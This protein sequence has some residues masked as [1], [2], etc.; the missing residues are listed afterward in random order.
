MSAWERAVRAAGVLA[1]LLGMVLTIG[2]SGGT[3][4]QEATGALRIVLVDDYGEALGGGCF[5]IVD[6][7]GAE[8]TACDDDGDGVAEVEGL[9][10]GDVTIAETSG[11]DGYGLAPEALAVVSAETVSSIELVS[12]AGVEPEEEPASGIPVENSPQTVQLA[13]VTEC[14]GV[15][16]ASIE[17]AG[18]ETFSP[19]DI[20]SECPDLAVTKGAIASTILVGNQAQ[21]W[22]NVVN[23]GTGT[24]F[25]VTL[26]DN[27]P[28][29]VDWTVDDEDCAIAD[30]LLTCNF[31]DLAPLSSRQ[32]LVS[33]GTAIANCGVLTNTA[34]ASA[35]NEPAE[36]LANNEA[37]AE[38]TATCPILFYLKSPDA[39]SVN[40]GEDIGFTLS[41][42]NQGLASA[43]SVTLVDH[44]PQ[45]AGLDWTIDAGGN[46][47]DCS[48]I[49]DEMSCAF[50]DLVAGGS[51]SVHISSSTTAE[52]C[53]VVSNSADVDASNTA[54][55]WVGADVTVNCPNIT[56]TKDAVNDEVTTGDELAFTLTIA[57][58]GQ[59]VATD[60]TV[61]DVLPEGI[62]WS[63]DEEGCE[64]ES[65]TLAC[66][67]PELG[68]VSSRLLLLQG[69]TSIGMC[70]TVTN[71]ASVVAANEPI[72]SNGDNSSTDSVE[73]TC[74]SVSI[75]KTGDDGDGNIV[76]LEGACFDLLRNEAVFDSGCTDENGQLEFV[77]IPV[78][79]YLLRETIAP[80][81]YEVSPISAPITLEPGE[82]AE[83]DI[84][85]ELESVEFPVFALA[86][87]EDPGSVDPVDIANGVLPQGCAA[88][89]GVSFSVVENGGTPQSFT[90][91][92]NGGFVVT[93][94]LFSTVEVTEDFDTVPGGYE[95][96]FDQALLTK[97]IESVQSD[98]AGLVFVSLALPTP[99]PTSTSTP[100]PTLTVTPAS[101]GT[102]TPPATIES[103][104]TPATGAPAPSPTP[105][106]V[107][108][109]PNT[110]TGPGNFGGSGWLLGAGLLAVL[111]LG[112][113]ALRRRS[114]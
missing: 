8:Q 108:S 42:E 9:I 50:G 97:T 54:S 31:G 63:V 93:V 10:E 33:G 29:G 99:E 51:L 56:I 85:N 69:E 87:L 67:F 65:G 92:V 114:S 103:T 22:V 102:P 61:T 113:L 21:F 12:P 106:T 78:T 20:D 47:E 90:T 62:A 95:P 72:A 80:E 35:T 40:A 4:A 1:L 43:T 48:V 109:L 49:D 3:S 73:I 83:V 2:R 98:E 104:P 66:E 82:T 46:A 26:V 91:G 27:L 39:F 14:G 59:G 100:M 58:T 53:G 30:T 79:T 57:N 15:G 32:I 55:G 25:G 41:I 112:G 6:A 111:A 76:P 70:G 52:T 89:S 5:R 37:S 74:G 101:T 60:I 88:V 64:I 18:E 75:N 81:H 24:A 84:E 107:N 36:A 38:I 96:A 94:K 44:L 11:R 110:G 77:D 68:A 23:D 19:A 71:T 28:S 13:E 16:P 7:S 45:N 34:S 17:T 105:V 86:C